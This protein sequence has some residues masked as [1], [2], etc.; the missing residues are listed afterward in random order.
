MMKKK[1]IIVVLFIMLLSGVFLA[2]IN[3]SRA[4]ETEYEVILED[5]TIADQLSFDF[6]YNGKI[7]LSEQN[8]QTVS[9]EYAGKIEELCAINGQRV[10]EN[11]KIASYRRFSDDEV[12]DLYASKSGYITFEDN[13]MI[14]SSVGQYAGI[15]TIYEMESPDDIFI[16][17]KVPIYDYN[18]IL[19]VDDI[20]LKLA[21]SD[22]NKQ[23]EIMD[24]IPDIKTIDG[25]DYYLIKLKLTDEELNIAQYNLAVNMP[26]VIYM[27]SVTEIDDTDQK[28]YTVPKSSLVIRDN[29][30]AIFVSVLKGSALYS[31]LAYVSV[32]SKK[33]DNAIITI[34]GQLTL[35]N[36]NKVITEGNYKLQGGEK[37]KNR[38]NGGYLELNLFDQ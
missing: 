21:N 10:N 19:N 23:L 11:D 12:I 27:N 17:C 24:T 4:E 26:V 29:K 3:R 28:Y 16:L 14:G 13:I 31:K 37:L 35:S 15:A 33:D 22:D 34:D 18:Y 8:K 20:R 36:S 38:S 32:I 9:V 5:I 7:I 2:N 25:I 6:E 30:D 1:I